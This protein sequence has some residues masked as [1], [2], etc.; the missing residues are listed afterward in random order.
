MPFRRD[1]VA[2]L[3]A[4]LM[5]A[6]SGSPRAQVAWASLL[7]NIS[8]AADLIGKLA[9]N[10]SEAVDKGLKTYDKVK[11]R[12]LKDLLRA[13]LANMNELNGRKKTNLNEIDDY[14]A[15]NLGARSWAQLQANWKEIADRLEALTTS[16]GTINVQLIEGAGFEN[17]SD[18][19]AALN[20]QKT[21]YLTLS[22]I[23]EPGGDDVDRFKAT[24]Q[25]LGD[26]MQNVQKLEGAIDRYV[27]Q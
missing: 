8:G 5:L 12:Q 25:K 26:L 6:A 21:M 15:H 22:T 11:L 4:S 27:R 14:L 16:L 20:Q 24:R 18:I 1:I 7:N 17:A 9:D 13:T 23:A 19:V 10:V 2:C 3:T